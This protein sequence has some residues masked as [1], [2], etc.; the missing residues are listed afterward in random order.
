MIWDGIGYF[1]EELQETLGLLLEDNVKPTTKRLLERFIEGRGIW[2]N[3]D[4]IKDDQLRGLYADLRSSGRRQVIFISHEQSEAEK[5][6]TL[7]HELAHYFIGK[8][9]AK[10]KALGAMLLEATKE[11]IKK[12][13]PPSKH[14]M[15]SVFKALGT[16]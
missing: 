11:T 6:E 1:R 7:S 5:L 8:E 12:A 9:E 14:S 3:W 15:Y 10:A 13:A 4:W 2:I 16:S